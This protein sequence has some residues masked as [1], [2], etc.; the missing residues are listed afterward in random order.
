M[1]VSKLSKLCQVYILYLEPLPPPVN[2]QLVETSS[3]LVFEWSEVTSNCPH[4]HYRINSSN[5]GQC[6]NTTRNMT[7]TC[8]GNF[9]TNSPSPCLFA[10]RSVLCVDIC[11]NATTVTAMIGIYGTDKKMINGTSSNTCTGCTQG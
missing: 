11:G 10:V 4:F 1:C 5:C 2:L 6:P 7:A 8:T 9:T 3:E